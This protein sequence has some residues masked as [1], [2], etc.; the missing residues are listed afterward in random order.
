[1]GLNVCDLVII[2]Q[3][4][5][6]KYRSFKRTVEMKTNNTLIAAANMCINKQTL[7]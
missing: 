6:E 4:N 3:Q 1:M 7:T 5:H 2:Y